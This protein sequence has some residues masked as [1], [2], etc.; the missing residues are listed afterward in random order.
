MEACLR[1][2]SSAIAEL[3]LD[4]GADFRPDE[5]G[6]EPKTGD[7][8]A[9]CGDCRA[10]VVLEPEEKDESSKGQKRKRLGGLL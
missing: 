3:E 5:N 2:G 6:I 9:E 10:F 1:C 4:Y 7:T 8:I